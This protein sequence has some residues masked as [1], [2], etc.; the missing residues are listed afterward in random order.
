LAES[1]GPTRGAGDPLS[2][3]GAPGRIHRRDRGDGGGLPTSSPT[4]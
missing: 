3:S 2:A 4:A 1:T